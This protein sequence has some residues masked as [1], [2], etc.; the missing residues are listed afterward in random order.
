MGTGAEAIYHCFKNSFLGTV[1]STVSLGDGQN[2]GQMYDLPFEH[3]RNPSD[4]NMN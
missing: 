1:D 3:D 4:P 2:V